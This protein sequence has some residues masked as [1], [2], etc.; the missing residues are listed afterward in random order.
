[1]SE[2]PGIVVLR[3]ADY[4][5]MRWKNG[6]GWTTEIAQAAAGDG[7]FAWR[8]SIAE[9]DADGDFSAFPGVDRSLLVLGGEGMALD[10]GAGAP[11]LVRALAEPAVFAGE[12]A[13]HARLLG[14]PTRDFNVMTRRDLYAHTLTWR[15][16][17]EPM[18][19]G[20]DP[21]RSWLVH[22]LAGAVH[23]VSA[24]DSFV[25]G[26]GPEAT[27]EVAGEATLVVV[28]LVRRA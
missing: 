15:G 13:V 18:G 27:L 14:G 10:F 1:M 26:E 24:G 9:V 16:P 22:V 25:L 17:G 5:R 6:A 4:R 8:V 21:I 28:G 7:G 23:G 11:T 20:R 3:R 19:L 2:S 12:A